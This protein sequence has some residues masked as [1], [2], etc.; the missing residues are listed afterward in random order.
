MKR[1][2][3]ILLGVLALQIILSAVVFWPRETASASGEPVFPELTVDDIVSVTIE[4]NLG[5]RIV[6]S[7][8][9]D[10]WVL[11][12][13]DDFPTQAD[14]VTPALEKLAGLTAGSVVARTEASHVQLEVAN[15]KFQRRI[16]IETTDGKTQTLYL[17]SAP[18][19][20]ATHFRLAG[21]AE[22]YLTSDLSVW[23]V[24][25]A[26]S[27]WADTSYVAIDQ[28]AV[29]GVTL[30]NANG[31]FMFAKDGDTWALADLQEDETADTAQAGSIVRTATT[32][33]LKE[34]LGRSASPAYGLD[35]PGA[36]I[37]V[38]TADGQTHTLT[39]GAT[40]RE[41]GDYVVKSSDSEFYVL[42]ASYTVTGLLEKTRDD[43]LTIPPTPVA[44]G[45]EVPT[46][47]PAP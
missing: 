21:Q 27:G 9:G 17:G 29:T 34:P 22:T 45:P 19:Y 31:T 24:G 1:S 39:I 36:V 2:Q 10:A 12:E 13:A 32:M 25:V 11:P 20:T 23:D 44:E 15:G 3:Q 43:F 16:D 8:A 38:S 7:K 41:S 30:M 47:T 40:P 37:D 26:I 6:L 35:D 18:R 14:R 28:E 4:D 33:A 5:G 46:P 42:V